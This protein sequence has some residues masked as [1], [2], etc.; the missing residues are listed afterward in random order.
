MDTVHTLRD[1]L[2]PNNIGHYG[3]ANL[4]ATNFDALIHQ[5]DNDESTHYRS[6]HAATSDI[7]VRGRIP[8]RTQEEK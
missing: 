8:P 5:K 7:I 4:V 6:A 2:S 1:V 3:E